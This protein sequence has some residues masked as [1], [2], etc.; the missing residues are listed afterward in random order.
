LDLC[1]FTTEGGGDVRPMNK[2]EAVEDAVIGGTVVSSTG[3]AA[4]TQIGFIY[5]CVFLYLFIFIIIFYL[6]YFIF[7]FFFF[8]FLLGGIYQGG[9]GNGGT[10]STMKRGESGKGGEGSQAGQKKPLVFFNN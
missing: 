5:T 7:L 4:A 1:R 10:S 9:R 6:L 2:T 3:T 8:F